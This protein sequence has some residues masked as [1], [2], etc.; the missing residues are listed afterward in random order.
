MGRSNVYTQIM[1]KAP[2]SAGETVPP[3]EGVL[4]QPPSTPRTPRQGGLPQG[5]TCEQ[6]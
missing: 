3:G 2:P 1:R 6:P 5:G 4:E